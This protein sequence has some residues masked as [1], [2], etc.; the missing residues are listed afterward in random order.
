[1]GC[2]VSNGWESADFQGS[3]GGFVGSGDV[4]AG[5]AR[6]MIPNLI[7]KTLLS[8][9]PHG[10]VHNPFFSSF[11]TEKIFPAPHT[12]IASVPTY[13]AA[14]IAISVIFWREIQNIALYWRVGVRKFYKPVKYSHPNLDSQR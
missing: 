11:F 10:S 1:M 3:F 4:A 2:Q 6:A 13:F 7:S 12:Y 8:G 9:L 14:T 5:R